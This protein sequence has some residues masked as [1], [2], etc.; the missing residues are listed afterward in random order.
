MSAKPRLGRIVGEPREFSPTQIYSDSQFIY[1]IDEGLGV[2]KRTPLHWDSRHPSGYFELVARKPMPAAKP[3]MEEAVPEA[4]SEMVTQALEV[5]SSTK[6]KFGWLKVGSLTAVA[7]VAAVVLVYPHLPRV[8]YELSQSLMGQGT[9]EA[10]AAYEQKPIADTNRLYIPKIGVE[11]AILEGK[12]LDVLNRQEGVWHQTGTLANDNFV[13]AGHRFKYL[14]P[15]TSTFYNLD[16]L[17][18]GDTIMVDWY[19]RRYLYKVTQR[20][21]VAQNRVDLLAQTP[22]PQLTLYTCSDESEKER[23]VVVAEPEQQL[24]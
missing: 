4:G 11:T 9:S 12:T 8:Q 15:N 14:P 20:F 5:K 18:V 21:T 7:V 1:R 22:S 3:E 16:K 13:L 23:V 2:C 24:H 19:Q 10:Q 6:P 17:S